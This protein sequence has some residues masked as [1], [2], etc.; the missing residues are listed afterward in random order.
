MGPVL[1][2][3][4][5]LGLMLL[6]FIACSSEPAKQWYKPTGNY[7]TDEFRRDRAAC[8]K[9]GD[10]DEDCLKARG[11]IGLSADPDKGQSPVDPK[12]RSK[13]NR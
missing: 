13:G 8:T 7:T 1:R 9:N 5:L 11:W 2:R 4:F 3:L 10:V 12:A 6:I